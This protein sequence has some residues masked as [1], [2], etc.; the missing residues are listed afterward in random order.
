M[1]MAEG[2]PGTHTDNSCVCF[3]K[4]IGMGGTVWP[5]AAAHARLRQTRADRL[6]ARPNAHFRT[7]PASIGNHR[8]PDSP[9]AQCSADDE[10]R[11]WRIR[12]F[13]EPL[14]NESM[15]TPCSV[16]A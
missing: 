4:L 6:A 14:E 15:A 16:K 7:P 8:L 3:W 5:S 10:A 11:Q 13:G 12:V 2:V 9:G 1:A